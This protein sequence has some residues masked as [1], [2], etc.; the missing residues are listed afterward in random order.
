MPKTPGHRLSARGA[1]LALAGYVLVLYTSP[2]LAYDLYVSVNNRVGPD[3]ASAWMNG[4]FAGAGVVVFLFLLGRRLRAS[5]WVAF[6]LIS[7][8]VAVC[9]VQ[10]D[11]PAKRFHFFQYAPLTLLV[12]TN[13]RRRCAH[14]NQY[15]WTLL[16][17]SLL[18]LGDEVI[19]GALPTR[20]F[21]VVDLFID[22][23]AALLTLAFVKFVMEADNLDESAQ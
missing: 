15:I 12:L 1:L 9:L 23:G 20:Y 16:I 4:A 3:T 8:C 2:S 21:G 22:S 19:Q 17:V 18:G 7:L 13:V 14:K 11:L 6:L 5:A 10:L